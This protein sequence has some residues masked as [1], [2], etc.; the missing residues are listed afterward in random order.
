MRKTLLLGLLCAATSVNAAYNLD[1]YWN[2]PQTA[3]NNNFAY[4][5]NV[6]KQAGKVFYD[7][8]LVYRITNENALDVIG[9]E[10]E[11]AV[12]EV[13]SKV[14]HEGRTYAV[15]SI[16]GLAFQ[17]C[18]KLETL[19]I[20]ASVDYIYSVRSRA[21]KTD[22]FFRSGPFYGCT[23]LKT[24]N[25]NSLKAQQLWTGDPQQRTLFNNLTEQ[26]VIN[27]PVGSD[28]SKWETF[29]NGLA[30]NAY[31][32][33]SKYGTWYCRKNTVV[34]SG[35]EVY[36]VKN[37]DAA[38]G[39]VELNQVGQAGDI[40]PAHT[41]V[42]LK[43]VHS[44]YVKLIT[45]S[46]AATIKELEG[47]LLVGSDDLVSENGTLFAINGGETNNVVFTKASTALSANAA[48]L[49]TDAFGLSMSG[50]KKLQSTEK[51]QKSYDLQGRRMKDNAKGITIQDRNKVLK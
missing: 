17:R 51:A 22:G 14:T 23:N 44:G 46:K 43:A 16:S 38:T 47:N 24:I 33:S 15:K 34:P 35:V 26:T 36:I 30:L 41:G 31:I 18:S 45:T 49:Q 37:F 20:P 40:I 13:P 8:P 6:D 1:I 42:V 2:T 5:Y 29:V 27:T 3:I 11:E 12:I 4:F 48:F 10:M 9:A 7:Y 50:I 19:T 25:N 28:Y 21:I 39:K 32:A